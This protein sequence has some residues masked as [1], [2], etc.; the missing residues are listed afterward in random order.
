MNTNYFDVVKLEKFRP[1]CLSLTK[2]MQ[3]GD[4]RGSLT[5]DRNPAEEAIL[6]PSGT[7]G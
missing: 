7:L 5:F 1:A 6:R 4:K 3:A 2:R